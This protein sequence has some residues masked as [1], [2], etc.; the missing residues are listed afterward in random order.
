MAMAYIV[1][2]L[3]DLPCL[4][5]PAC[6]LHVEAAAVNPVLWLDVERRLLEE[7][8]IVRDRVNRDRVLAREV[9]E[10][11]RKERLRDIYLWLM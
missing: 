3:T 6:A 9:L 8:E 2:A 7:F 4:I 10:R 1:M 11:A 5:V